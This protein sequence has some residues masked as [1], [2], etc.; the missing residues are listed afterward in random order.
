M[1]LT[2]G[3]IGLNAKGLPKPLLTCKIMA[4]F[5]G[6]YKIARLKLARFVNGKI[7]LS[8]F[9][10][11]LKILVVLD[12]T[13]YIF[14]L[15]LLLQLIQCE[16]SSKENANIQNAS[17]QNQ[18]ANR[19]DPH[20]CLTEP[21]RI[22][23]HYFLCNLL[24]GPISFVAGIPFQRNVMKKTLAGWEIRRN[25]RVVNTDPDIYLKGEQLWETVFSCQQHPGRNSNTLSYSER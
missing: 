14:H 4:R 23:Q 20:R 7:I 13:F 5:F 2:P 17:F 18:Y 11:A 24:T 15:I 6:L 22:L 9:W 12:K 19:V 1:T 8:I 3:C 16:I 10:P 21:G 25:W